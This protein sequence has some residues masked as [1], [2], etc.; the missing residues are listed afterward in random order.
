MPIDRLD[1]DNLTEGD[2]VELVAGQVPE[3]LRIEYKRDLYGNTDAARREALKDVSAFANAFG[4][5][6]LIGIEEQ[7]GAPVALPGI[8][9]VN[10]DDVVL[11]LDQ[12]VRSGIEPRIQG[13]RIRA[14]PLASGAHCF[15]LRIPRSWQP[16]HRVIAQNSNRFWIRNSG[17]AH[18]ASV[19][20][21]RTLFTLGA[22]AV[23]RVH[24]FRDK[25]MEEITTG[26]G[27]RPLQA[28]GRLILHIVP[29]AAVT[30]PFQVDLSEAYR[31]HRIFR[32]ISSTSMN[33][34][35]NFE[36]FVNERGGKHNH[37]YTQLFR[38]GSLEA[39]KAA[40]V[41]THEGQ[42]FIRGR[43]LESH[44]FEVLTGYINGLSDLE[45]PAPLVVLI[46]L[47][48][49]RGAAYRVQQHTPDDPE[50]AIERDILFLPDCIVNEYACD[51]DYHRS[52][53]PAF[54]ALW[55]AAGRLSAQT[56]SQDGMWIGNQ[57]Q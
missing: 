3:G 40:I 19:E 49:V 11:R 13:L 34:R 56:F 36:G 39:T 30:S 48:G 21:L 51:G 8:A 12:L 15:A 25:R 31:L 57:C 41:K 1:F 55:N 54:D 52:V 33:A 32:P 27:A 28:G 6:L 20:E 24:Q 35:F 47:E 22:D 7:K 10:P 18:E 16:P 29:L 50:P 53:K 5:S 44:I 46:T 45:I 4:G 14:V 37:G 9:N 26:R 2:L 38:N 23:D 43:D 42:I 17:G